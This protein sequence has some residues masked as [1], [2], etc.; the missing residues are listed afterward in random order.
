MAK[1]GTFCTKW[2]LYSCPITFVDRHMI[3]LPIPISLHPQFR[4]QLYV[5]F[6]AVL[7][8]RFKVQ[9]LKDAYSV[10]SQVKED[11]TLT[12]FQKKVLLGVHK[13]SRNR[14]FMPS[15]MDVEVLI[16]AYTGLFQNRSVYHII[17][18]ENFSIF[19]D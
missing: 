10:E 6:C 18:A 11:D 14:V 17:I 2:S 4:V 3:N 7:L 19:V 16:H 8:Y 12:K 9:W 5:E 13:R 15:M 1:K